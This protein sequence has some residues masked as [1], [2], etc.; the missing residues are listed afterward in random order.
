M[1][2][3]ATLCAVLSTIPALGAE[4]DEKRHYTQAPEIAPMVGR[5]PLRPVPN[6]PPSDAAQTVHEFNVRPGFQVEHLFTVPKAELGSWVSLTVDDKGRI[7]ASDQGG[8]GLSRITPPAPGSDE[9]TKVEHLAVK[10]SAAQGLLHAFGALYVSSSGKGLYRLR[11][12]NGDDQYDEVVQLMTSRGG[13]EHGEHALR[14][15][16]DGKSILW[17]AGNFTKLPIERAADA[18]P[19]TLGGVRAQ[20]LRASLPAGGQSRLAPIWDE[21]ILT[22]RQW[23]SNGFAVGVLAPGGWIAKTDPDG[24]QWELLSSGFRNEYDFALNADGEIFAYDADMENHIGLPWYR[25]TR[26]MHATSGSEFGWRSGSAKWP[27]YY[28][29]S[30]PETINIGPGSPVGVE[31]GYGAKFPAKYQRALFLCDF[32]F[33][34]IYAVSLTPNGSSYTAVKEEFLSRNAL[35][36][37]DAVVGKDGALYFTIGGRGN[38]SEL[39][40]VTYVGAESTAPVEYKQ[41]AGAD[42]RALRRE[43]ETYHRPDADPTQAVPFLVKHLASPDR[44]IR[45]AARVGL[46]RIP[47]QYWLSAV[48]DSHDAN[49]VITGIVGLARTVDAAHGP[50]LI[51]RLQ[52]INFAELNETQQ[53]EI[54]RA[55]ELALIRCGLPDGPGTLATGATMLPPSPAGA[56]ATGANGPKL[57][58]GPKTVALGGYFEQFF[59]SSSMAVNR[60]LTVLMVALEAPH[61]AE[62]LVP[63]LKHQPVNPKYDWDD[64]ASWHRGAIRWMLENQLDP[65]HAHIALHLR[66][67]QTGWTP[68]LRKT[69]FAWFEQARACRGGSSFQRHLINIDN[70]A[71]DNLS[72]SEKVLIEAT[73]ARKPF[74]A[75]ELPKPTGPGKDYSL[76]ELSE[77]AASQLKGR[78]FENGKKMFAAGRCVVCHRFAGVGGATGPELTQAA[79]RYS[80]RDLIESIIDPNKVVSDQYKTT[81]ITTSAGKNL[82]G[83]I[84]AVNDATLTLL[85]DPED[86]TKLVTIPKSEIE[87]QTQ[88]PLSLMPKD[89]LKQLNQDEVLDLIAYVLS[90]D[91]KKE[92]YFQ[93]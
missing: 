77:L 40:R 67:L 66:N 56:P 54:L 57:L 29:D 74:K 42:A 13:G 86:S 11:D 6:A 35:P 8:L 2:Y 53:I 44:F 63:L 20:Q 4:N 82:T 78:D 23:D 83:R 33:G 88:S 27:A 1:R 69:Y 58:P 47:V 85:V 38:Q 90:R 91:N 80:A 36:L 61:A 87:E 22:L 15:G 68:E 21:D 24:K 7:I 48:L 39:F 41:A 73:G 50:Q 16:P 31:F 70:E 72:D 12:T 52:Q 75:A 81:I 65:L 46:E 14:I 30:L 84:V 45:Y 32:T 51:A 49:T 60:E 89:L 3:L 5:A 26:V 9:P 79:G 62:L 37:T 59:P 10:M 17:C 92:R 43:I 93:Q 19:Q 25:P 34:T 64:E 76:D 18:P 28:V 55:Y 71:F